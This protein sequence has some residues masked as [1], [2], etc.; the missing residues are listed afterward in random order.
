MGSYLRSHRPLLTDVLE[1]VT[2]AFITGALGS[3]SAVGLA[4][5]H[6]GAWRSAAVG[7]TAAVL[8]LIRGMVAS[9]RGDPGNASLLSR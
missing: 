1:R 4:G 8:E 6:A 2:A 7:G 9:R 3:A 5:G